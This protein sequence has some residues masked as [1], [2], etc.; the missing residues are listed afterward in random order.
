MNVMTVLCQL[1]INAARCA[2]VLKDKMRRC[3]LS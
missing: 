3:H 2:V 1:G